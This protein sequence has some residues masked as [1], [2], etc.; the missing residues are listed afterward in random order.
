MC[1][2]VKEKVHVVYYPQNALPTSKKDFHKPDGD[3]IAYLCLIDKMSLPDSE[4]ISME[5]IGT[6]LSFS[7]T[8][9]YKN[10]IER[11]KGYVTEER[12]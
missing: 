11:E 6:Y 8:K 7:C 9:C 2:L 5:I 3:I 12:T 1:L 10:M 4:V